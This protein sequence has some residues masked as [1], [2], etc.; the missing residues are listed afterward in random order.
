MTHLRGIMILV[1]SI[2][3]N[4]SIYEMQ[5]Y[6]FQ[7]HIIKR[8]NSY[9]WKFIWLGTRDAMKFHILSLE[10]IFMSKEVV[11]WGIKN[12]ELF[13]HATLI[14]SLW[15]GTRIWKMIIKEKYLKGQSTMGWMKGGACDPFV[16]SYAW[17]NL[18][19][20]K[21][22]LFGNLQWEIISR[23]QMDISLDPI[24]RFN[25]GHTLLVDIIG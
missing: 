3:Q 4:I 15:R 11:G 13:G 10:I 12:T 2:L 25:W 7:K 14:K 9:I 18:I 20:N 17:N 5:F 21:C 6:L 23:K 19:K 16:V 1:Q 24:K 8:I 22:W